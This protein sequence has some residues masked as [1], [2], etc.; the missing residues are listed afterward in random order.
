MTLKL[1]KRDKRSLVVLGV[2][3]LCAGYDVFLFEPLY[4]KWE[5]SAS[6]LKKNKKELQR[7]HMKTRE[8]NSWSRDYDRYGSAIKSLSERV[9][10]PAVGTGQAEILKALTEAANSASIK[11]TNLRPIPRY[12]D[13]NSEQV[14]DTF[15]IDG[16][17]DSDGYIK[18]LD[19]LWGMEILEMNL[20]RSE[21]ESG[22]LRFFLKIMLHNHDIFSDLDLTGFN[23]NPIESFKLSADPFSRW[24]QKKSPPAPTTPRV[25]N[26][27]KTP[28]IA[29]K[30]KLRGVVLTGVAQLGRQKVAIA[31]ESRTNRDLFWAIGE[32]YK[33]FEV[34]DINIDG[35]KLQHV[36]YD[37]PYTLPL[38]SRS[39]EFR[40]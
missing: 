13:E 2:F 35:V 36:E 14:I 4:K 10:I 32:N 33:N 8:L 34:I 24:A 37:E 12:L 30:P 29:P 3:L 28:P 27:P 11:I 9:R 23:Y 1:S 31:R 22:V 16:F 25:S 39:D 20:V 26:T 40:L 17:A 15:I 7:R 6:E 18:F 38:P 19:E 21:K 5:S